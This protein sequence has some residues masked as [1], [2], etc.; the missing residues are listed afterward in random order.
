ME[1]TRSSRMASQPPPASDQPPARSAD[2]SEVRES[3]FRYR[4]LFETAPDGI[5]LL[6]ADDGRIAD[7]NPFLCELLGYSRAELQGKELWQIG[8]VE[9][10]AASQAAF[11]RL[12]Q[13]GYERREDLPLRNRG[14]AQIE[15]E[16][17]S[18]VYRAGS[19]SVIQCN[20]RDVS[21]R[22]RVQKESSRLAA[23]L[24]DA[25]RRKDEFLA[26][27]SHELRNPLSPILNAVGILRQQGEANPLEHEAVNIIEQQTVQL[28]RIIDDLLEISRIGTGRVHLRRLA[29]EL[30]GLVQRTVA[31]ARPLMEVR[32][33]RF[34]TSL[35]THPIWLNADP[36]RLVQV[37]V[38]LLDNAAKYT[39]EGGQIT[40]TVRLEGDCA[41]IRVQ[42]TGVGI[43]RALLPRVFE[44]FSQ[45]ESSRECAHGGLGIGLALVRHLV[46]LHQGSVAAESDGPGL[47]SQFVVRLPLTAVPSSPQHHR[48]PT[49]SR[50]AQA[51]SRVLV[52]DEDKDR[53][54]G[55]VA[56]LRRFG[57][58]TRG[59]YTVASGVATALKFQPCV[60]LLDVALPVMGGFEVVWRLRQEP[61]SKAV[62]LVALTDDGDERHQRALREAGFDHHLVKPV[63]P[64]KLLEFLAEFIAP[65]TTA[66]V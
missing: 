36:D 15:V 35:E 21:D 18:N 43:E 38:N 11:Q 6:D 60:V 65:Q 10:I 28:A 9:N 4:R 33:Q 3:E 19:E 16:F 53:A 52:I 32:G 48:P 66:A 40:L 55:A 58:E 61:K 8:L 5:L 47:G 2:G 37:V 49:A 30:N 62:P 51:G 41:V 63:D 26:M 56:L 34:S 12:Q 7:A 29:V 27:V 57:F 17:V 44:L 14:G 46:E 64:T 45:G 13:N 42:D 54:D 50:Q 22:M 39:A 25:Y 24:A 23:N 20:I 1:T 31:A 59:A